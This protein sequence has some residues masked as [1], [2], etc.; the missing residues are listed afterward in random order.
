MVEVKQPLLHPRSGK[1]DQLAAEIGEFNMGD[2]IKYADHSVNRTREE[3]NR[4]CEILR[5]RGGL[6]GKSLTLIQTEDGVIVKQIR[7]KIT[8]KVLVEN[9]QPGM[10]SMGIAN[11]CASQIDR[12]PQDDPTRGAAIIYLIDLLT[13]HLKSTYRGAKK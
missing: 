6:R 9:T 13:E 11:M 10:I 3:F 7:K 2:T 5:C 4:S 12:M 1:A 8:Q